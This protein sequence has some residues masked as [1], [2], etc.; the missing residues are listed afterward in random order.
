MTHEF[1]CQGRRCEV[2]VGLIDGGVFI[3]GVWGNATI[4]V[5]QEIE[6]ALRPEVDDYYQHGDGIYLVFAEWDEGQAADYEAVGHNWEIESS[7]GADRDNVHFLGEFGDNEGILRRRA[8]VHAAA[9]GER[10]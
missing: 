5:L 10:Q 9:K 3:C 6:A 7:W 4:D 1:T 2:E 8:E